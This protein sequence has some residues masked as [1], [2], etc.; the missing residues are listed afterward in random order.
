LLA[1]LREVGKGRVRLRV[2]QVQW[3]RVG[4]DQADEALADL[5]RDAV[6]GLALEALRG[7]ELEDAIGAQDVGR[8]DF[9][10]HV[11]RDLHDDL[12][13]PDLR[14]DRLRHDLAQAAE[15]YAR[16][17][18]WRPHGR[19]SG[20]FS[21]AI[22]PDYALSRRWRGGFRTGSVVQPV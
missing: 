7:I 20:N 15:E 9:R 2:R 17:R 8:A 6:D 11:G 10:D 21:A 3:L 5:E 4:R 1:G 12:V 13:E 16:P 19:C 14:A 22:R 18:K